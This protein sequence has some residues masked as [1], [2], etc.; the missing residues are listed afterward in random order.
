MPI[1]LKFCLD[2]HTFNFHDSICV[3]EVEKSKCIQKLRNLVEE[4]LGSS[5]CNPMP[6]T[7]A[8]SHQPMP[9]EQ[10]TQSLRHSSIPPTDPLPPTHS[11]SP[12]NVSSPPN[13]S[14]LPSGS[15]SVERKFLYSHLVL[16]TDSDTIR[17]SI[18][19]C[20]LL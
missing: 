15:S 14:R 2:N 8:S 16:T 12:T 20:R 10:P 9:G 13:H 11:P 4:H 7:M 5:Q 1:D 6:V 18:L 17:T 3:S 19:K